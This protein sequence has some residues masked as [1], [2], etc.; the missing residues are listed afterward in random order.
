[1]LVSSMVCSIT[2]MFCDSKGASTRGAVLACVY[3]VLSQT[4][5]V[6][7]STL[8]VHVVGEH[9]ELVCHDCHRPGTGR[10]LFVQSLPID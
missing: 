9:C 3:F 1:M 4:V 10:Q 8:A 5:R 7:C 6:K 2:S